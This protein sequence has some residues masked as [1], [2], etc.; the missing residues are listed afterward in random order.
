MKVAVIK[1][2]EKSI[3]VPVHEEIVDAIK[4]CQNGLLDIPYEFQNFIRSF[5]PQETVESYIDFDGVRV[6]FIEKAHIIDSLEY[7]LT[8]GMSDE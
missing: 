1:V 2:G 5:L 6:P 8:K 3:E 4:S 7:S